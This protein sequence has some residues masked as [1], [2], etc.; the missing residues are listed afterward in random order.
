MRATRLWETLQ[1]RHTAM[2]SYKAHHKAFVHRP[3]D[4][5]KK[6]DPGRE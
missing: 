5:Y 1:M 3:L 4:R 6:C 2:Y